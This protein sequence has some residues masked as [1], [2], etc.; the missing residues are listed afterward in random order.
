MFF[1]FDGQKMLRDMKTGEELLMGTYYHLVLSGTSP[2]PVT[3]KM[4]EYIFNVT[5]WLDIDSRNN[6]VKLTHYP[7][8]PARERSN[9]TLKIMTYNIWNFNPDWKQRLVRITDEVK[10]AKP[11]IV[12]FQEVR[13]RY[14]DESG[15]RGTFQVEELS[16]KLGPQYQFYYQHSM[17]YLDRRSFHE[18]EGNAI[19][20]LHPIRET[21][22]IRMSRDLADGEDDHQRIVTR[23]LVETPHVG[24]VNMHSTHLSL[25]TESRR[26]TVQELWKYLQKQMERHECPQVIVGDMNAEPDDIFIRFLTGKESIKGEKGS[27]IDT[28]E[29]LY[30]SEKGYTFPTYGPPMKR[31]DFVL[32]RGLL[33]PVSAKILSKPASKALMSSDHLP[34]MVQFS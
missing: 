14:L 20:S 4:R 32:F 25:S 13:Y 21:D 28:W 23:V 17:T 9:G 34:L 8:A 11:D 24:N 10:E 26:R 16:Q 22:F 19:F 15:Q 12:A 33:N 27:M 30:P 2:T 18:D 1:T 31:I 7:V 6:L 5:V 3:G 29:Y